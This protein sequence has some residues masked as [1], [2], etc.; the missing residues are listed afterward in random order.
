ME[1]GPILIEHMSP[2]VRLNALSLLIS[3]KSASPLASGTLACLKRCVPYFNME[4]EPK[5]RNE[6][7]ALMKIMAIKFQNIIRLLSRQDTRESHEDVKTDQAISLIEHL[8]FV[9]WYTTF[10]VFELRPTASY[11]SHITSLKVL[12]FFVDQVAEYKNSETLKSSIETK[13]THLCDTGTI[14]CM[15]DL[16]LNPFDDVRQAVTSILEQI[17]DSYATDA[18]SAEFLGKLEVLLKIALSR[19]EVAFRQ[20]GRA[21]HSDGFGR[22]HALLFR[23]KDRQ[24]SMAKNK[25]EETLHLLLHELQVGANALQQ[26]FPAAIKISSLHGYL[27]SLRYVSP[28]PFTRIHVI[29]IL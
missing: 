4:V 10:L 2:S 18:T 21:D 23:L 20:S 1:L 27:I 3:S 14:R 24:G 26:N 29:D 28:C 12:S 17:M 11:Q 16:L 22:L 19:A 8:N 15:I 6:F 7:I 5:S 25:H 9:H 13:I